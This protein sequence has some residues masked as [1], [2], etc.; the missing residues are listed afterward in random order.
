[1]KEDS[2]MKK[3]TMKEDSRADKVVFKLKILSKSL[4]KSNRLNY[5][6]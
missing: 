4:I 3:Y 5:S 1:M 2:T 6:Q